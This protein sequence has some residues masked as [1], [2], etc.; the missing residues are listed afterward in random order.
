MSIY[1]SQLALCQRK[2][3]HSYTQKYNAHFFIY[4]TTK[5][6]GKI[7]TES[8]KGDGGEIRRENTEQT[9]SLNLK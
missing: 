8:K 9:V 3:L 6:K 7:R 4:V 2:V 5:Y 1:R